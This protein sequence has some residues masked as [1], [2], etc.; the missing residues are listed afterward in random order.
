[1]KK[2]VGE[3]MGELNESLKEEEIE[4][5]NSVYCKYDL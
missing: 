5:M 3:C 1:M 4:W 2:W